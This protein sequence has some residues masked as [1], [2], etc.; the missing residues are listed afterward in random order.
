MPVLVHLTPAKNV[1]R[2]L[3]SGIHQ[4]RQGVYCLPVLQSYYVSH[5]WMRELKRWG[6]RTFIGI[7]F[8]VPDDEMVWFGHYNQPHQYVTVSEAI[9]QLMQQVD[10]QGYEIIIPRSI[11]AKELHKIRTVSRVVGWRY[12]PGV[13]QCAWCACPICVSRGEIKSRKK[14]LQHRRAIDRA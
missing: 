2:I 13:R 8:H 7:Y 4:S 12:Q 5:Q 11:S 10:P 9:S 1:K 3:R 6:Q 14:R